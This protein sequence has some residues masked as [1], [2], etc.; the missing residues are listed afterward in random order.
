MKILFL[1]HR[2][3]PEI[4]G[5]EV[6]SEILANHFGL[7]GNEIHL[8]T[9]TKEN[10][11]KDFPFKII[12]NPSLYTLFKEHLWADV[13]Y[14]NNPCLR[15]SWPSY[16]LKKPRVIALRTW[17]SRN[18]GSLAI[19]DKLKLFWLSKARAVIAVS[20]AVRLNSWAGATVIGNPYRNNLF[21]ILNSE[22]R[23]NSFV[24]L[25]RLVSDK[26]VDLAIKALYSLVRDS[27]FSNK[28]FLT[29]IGNGEEREAL[30]NLVESLNLKKHVEFKGSLS[31]EELVLELN[32]H[33]F[34]LVPSQWK[35]P[36]G[37]IV[38]E[39]MAC[40][41]IPIVSD[42]GGL[43]DAVGKAGLT[44]KRGD[45]DSLVLC[46]N[47]IINDEILEWNLRNAASEHLKFHYPD[48]VSSRYLEVIYNAYP[49][50][51]KQVNE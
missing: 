21:R 9:W 26:G 18:D 39:G 23:G 4:G 7:Q 29:I 20:N 46:I 50:R 31:G 13:V 24:F 44:F 1:T 42:G 36:F 34:L 41:C 49:K 19:Q 48:I 16:L 11:S 15:L 30:E 33:K 22:D 5:I 25:G 51:H 8:V 28:Y 43:P 2:F 35:E 38:L 45:L 47:S 17:V 3:Y 6:N 27:G 40:G 14:E 37:N 12:R 32:K 10:G